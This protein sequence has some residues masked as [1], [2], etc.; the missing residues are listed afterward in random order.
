MTPV[1]TVS[2]SPSK[3]KIG[4]ASGAFLPNTGSI[5]NTSSA[6]SPSSSMT[7]L[8]SPSNSNPG[9][10][11]AISGNP[12]AVGTISTSG[13]SGDGS[14]EQTPPGGKDSGSGEQAPSG[15]KSGG[16][17][18][19]APS[20]GKDSG[21]GEQAPSGG[22]DGGSGAQTPSGGTGS[23]GDNVNKPVID[24]KDVHKVEQ[25]YDIDAIKKELV[26][27][28]E[29]KGLHYD[30]SLRVG[31]SGIGYPT[32]T[33]VL[34]DCFDKAD[35]IQGEKGMIDYIIRI[36]YG[37]AD[38]NPCFVRKSNQVNDYRVYELYD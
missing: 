33:E 25:P 34:Q 7:A 20:G 21:S 1:S 6:L 31:D 28:G 3:E 4:K 19:Q 5:R 12:A 13:N 18:E 29:S 10:Q 14:G 2:S 35:L 16:S 32:P 23:Y 37:G 22:T 36:G 15:G 24:S 8:F 38:F 26:A 11:A 17:G 27:Y 9:S 30:S